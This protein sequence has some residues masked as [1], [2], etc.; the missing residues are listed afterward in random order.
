MLFSLRGSVAVF[1]LRIDGWRYNSYFFFFVV[2]SRVKRSGGVENE[3]KARISDH[4][5]GR[6]WDS[7]RY[8]SNY[9]HGYYITCYV[10]HLMCWL[11]FVSGAGILAATIRD[12][13]P[14]PFELCPGCDAFGWHLR[15][16][17]NILC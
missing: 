16:V 5:F 3:R 1:G 8:S 11:F 7:V 14:A 12:R 2:L 17:S 13:L 6:S 10:T 15:G 9:L 4:N